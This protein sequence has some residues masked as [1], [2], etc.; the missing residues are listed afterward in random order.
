MSRYQ[1]FCNCM[2]ASNYREQ[3]Q[4]FSNLL[5]SVELVSKSK[6]G[7]SPAQANRLGEYS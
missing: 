1:N 6:V 5:T 2:L 3:F 7:K 4:A